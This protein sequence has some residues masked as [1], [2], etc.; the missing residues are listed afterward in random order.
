MKKLMLI[1]YILL[2]PLAANAQDYFAPNLWK[3]NGIT[4]QPVNSAWTLSIPSVTSTGDIFVNSGNKIGFDGDGDS[5]NYLYESSADNVRWR[6]GVSDIWQFNASAMGARANQ[7]PVIRNN[8]PSPT[9]PVF[10]HDNTEPDNGLGGT[11]STLSL[12]IAG[13][14]GLQVDDTTGVTTGLPFNFAADAEASDTYVIMLASAP[15]AYST[16]MMIVFTANTANTGACT[17]NVNGLGA[18]SLK[19][20]HDQDPGNSY[21][22]AGSVVMAVYDGTN[23]QMIQPA[24]N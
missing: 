9:T 24:A 18:K 13:V 2:L 14:E 20:L 19:M 16:G 17:V 8:Q 22:E 12:I 15:A 7:G 5:D 4:L 10:T 6:I 1:L 3:L 23:F 21:I 11:D